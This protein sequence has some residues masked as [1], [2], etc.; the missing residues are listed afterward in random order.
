MDHGADDAILQPCIGRG[1]GPNALEIGCERGERCTGPWRRHGRQ[2][3]LRP[4]PRGR[5][6]SSIAPPVR[7]SPIGWPGRQ[8]T[9]KFELV[10]NVQTARMLGRFSGAVFADCGFEL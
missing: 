8:R 2:S 5:A 10:I 3:W 4:L 9:T 6:P 1:G 7:R